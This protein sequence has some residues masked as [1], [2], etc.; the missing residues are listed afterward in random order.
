MKAFLAL[1]ALYTTVWLFMEGPFINR[2]ALRPFTVSTGEV[3]KLYEFSFV[4]GG[5]ASVTLSDVVISIRRGERLQTVLDVALMLVPRSL[6]SLAPASACFHSGLT[7]RELGP[8][9]LRYLSSWELLGGQDIVATWEASQ[10]LSMAVIVSNCTP[11]SRMVFLSAFSAYNVVNGTRRYLSSGEDLQP[12]LYFTLAALFFLFF[13]A[14]LRKMWGAPNIAALGPMFAATVLL[15]SLGTALRG[16]GYL[17][18]L[19][20]RS[21]EVFFFLATAFTALTLLAIMTAVLAYLWTLRREVTKSSLVLLYLLFASLL[22]AGSN[23]ASHAGNIAVF[24]KDISLSHGRVMLL[25]GALCCAAFALV[26]KAEAPAADQ[27]AKASPHFYSRSSLFYCL[28]VTF[29]FVIRMVLY[30]STSGD[31]R[32]MTWTVDFSRELATLLWFFG[33]S[34]PVMNVATR[35][36][37]L[38]LA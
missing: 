12:A 3:A 32:T 24:S 21:A 25:L 19:R 28:Y 37:Y 31:A 13:V 15:Q 4:Q 35:K 18:Q 2:L 5:V 23:V 26:L 22:I 10:D 17:A 30:A 29:F 11:D 33:A 16:L 6:L 7:A 9:T 27:P 1:V 34:Q 36:D 14:L 38:S 20:N 8:L